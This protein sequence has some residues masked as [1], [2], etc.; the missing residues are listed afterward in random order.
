MVTGHS[1]W[2]P[3]LLS[4]LL[5]LSVS[6]CSGERKEARQPDYQVDRDRDDLDG[7]Q[8]MQEFGGMNEEK[9]NKT[10]ERLQPEL[11]ECLMEGYKRVEFLGGEFAFLVKVDVKGDAVAAQAERSTLGDYQTEQCMLGKLKASKWPKPVGGL[12]GLARSSVEFDPPSD[13]R[14]P[15]EWSDTD[16]TAV[17]AEAESSLRSC[18]SGGPFSLT[19][20][21]NTK[22]NVM[23]AGVA[24]ADDAGDDVAACLVGAVQNLKFPSPGSWPAK[25]SFRR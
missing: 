5:V 19:A 17:L 18:G 12:I 20:Y 2:S 25:V 22:G 16:V 10:L 14:A 21:V 8:M 4:S 15:V 11:E 7:M 3:L 6:A 23:S 9:V 24:H 13:V 1:R